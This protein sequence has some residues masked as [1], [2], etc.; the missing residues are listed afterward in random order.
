MGARQNV[1]SILFWSVDPATFLTD[2]YTGNNSKNTPKTLIGLAVDV[3]RDRSRRCAR[4]ASPATG[5]S[6]MI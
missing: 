3:E 6:N 1:R 5:F 2:T 4:H